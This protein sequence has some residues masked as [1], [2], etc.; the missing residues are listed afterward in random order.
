MGF[1]QRPPPTPFAPPNPHTHA[2]KQV[3]YLIPSGQ[4]PT[5]AAMGP[6]R[7][8]AIYAVARRHDLLVVEDDAYSWLQ[9]PGGEAAV[10]GLDGL[11]RERGR[12]WARGWVVLVA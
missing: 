2:P 8:R 6:E 3:V 1:L 9:Y 12:G 7:R 10:P 5:G 4:N 11:Q